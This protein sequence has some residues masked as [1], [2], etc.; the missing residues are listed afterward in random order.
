M[1]KSDED[2]T[3]ERR[4]GWLQVGLVV[5]VGVAAVVLSEWI[6]SFAETPTPEE[7]AQERVLTVRAQR[8]SPSIERIRFTV[9]GTVQVRSYVQLVPE[10]SGRVVEVDESL[11]P[12][13][14]FDEGAVLFEIELEDYR[15]ARSNRRA[16]VA[17]AKRALELRE[18][19]SETAKRQWSR[20]HPDQDPPPL[21]AK[22]PQL[23]EARANLEAAESRLRQAELDLQRA[24]F[25]LPF[26][27]RVVDSTIEKGQFVTAGRSYGRVYR[28]QALEVH[29]PVTSRQRRWLMGSTE[30]EIRIGIIHDGERTEYRG[31]FSRMAA[32]AEPR[33]RFL[34]AIFTFGEPPASVSPREFAEVTVVGP[35]LQQAWVLP[36]DALQPGDALWAIDEE[37]RLRKIQ[38]E[39]L[40]V[41]EEHVIARGD[42]Q[43]VTV[44]TGPLREATP[45]TKVEVRDDR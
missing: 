17:K 27:G 43:A 1:A 39:I 21:V 22:I 18:A 24:R 37:S 12:G 45:G 35:E 10:V 30:P 9:T 36:I 14:H 41:T 42:G 26:S 7:P 40:Q 34:V 4:K 19:E 5:L 38:P 25:S 2:S 20:L 33:T 13:R 29:A 23:E 31:R 11:S 15:L 3:Y 32:E 28:D 16:A 44:V 6:A 8:V